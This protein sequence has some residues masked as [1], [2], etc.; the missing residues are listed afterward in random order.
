MSATRAF[1]TR[2]LYQ[3]VA[4][5]FI[6]RIVSGRWAPGQVIENESEIARSLG[7]S[8]GTVRKAFEI[9]A[10]HK[11]LERHQ[12]RGTIV[13]DFGSREARSRFSNIVDR[14]GNRVSGDLTIGPVSIERPSEAVAD[15]LAVNGRTPVIR[16]RRLRH[17]QGRCFMHEDVYLRTVTGVRTMSQTDL[18]QAAN[19]RWHGTD[20]ATGKREEVGA[21]P[22]TAEDA[23]LLVG[24]GA[25]AVLTLR[26]VVLSY[27]DRPLELRFG[28][29]NLGPDLL[30]ATR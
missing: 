30:Y 25:A 5:E 1:N 15:A 7:I 22:A 9:V 10:G 18:E 14:E 4:D 21:E 3:Q 16:F 29:C 17:F 8:L 26:R 28:R 11:L 6:G 2:P 12:G 19:D 23:E 24:I 13:T 20:L 27:Q